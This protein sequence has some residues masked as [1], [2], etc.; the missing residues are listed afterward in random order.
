MRVGVCMEGLSSGRKAK[1]MME[2]TVLPSRYVRMWLS[3]SH[4]SS[5]PTTT[6]AREGGEGC[7]QRSYEI[8][9]CRR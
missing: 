1:G 4:L 8:F 5:D 3:H 7:R 9:H 6:G 2:R